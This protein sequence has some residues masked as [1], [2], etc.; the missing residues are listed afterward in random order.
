VKRAKRRARK[1]LFKNCMRG[2]SP[3]GRPARRRTKQRATPTMLRLREQFIAAIRKR[4]G[5][6]MAAPLKVKLDYVGIGRK[7]QVIEETPRVVS[8]KA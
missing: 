5:Q 6:A 7:L 3:W 1:Y 8:V 4:I 2:V